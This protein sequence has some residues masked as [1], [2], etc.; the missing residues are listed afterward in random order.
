MARWK[1]I[2]TTYLEPWDQY[3]VVLEWVCVS[4]FIVLIQSQLDHSLDH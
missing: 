2:K 4:L 3:Q 1:R